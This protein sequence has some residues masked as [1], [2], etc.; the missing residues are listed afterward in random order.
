MKAKLSYLTRLCPGLSARCPPGVPPAHVAQM[1]TLGATWRSRAIHR[2]DFTV[3]GP[4]RKWPFPPHCAARK[5]FLLPVSLK[6]P[7]VVS[8]LG[9]PGKGANCNSP[10]PAPPAFCILERS[11]FNTLNNQCVTSY[12]L[13]IILPKPSHQRPPVKRLQSSK[14]RR[15][16]LAAVQ[17]DW[18]PRGPG[19]VPVPVGRTGRGFSWV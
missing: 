12:L 19:S 14:V 17:E 7:V 16:E 13:S 6:C 8:D 5:P 4:S 10:P 18:P 9:S 3:W 15:T 1:E 2:S 11:L